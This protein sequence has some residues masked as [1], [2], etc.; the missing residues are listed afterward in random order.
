M[1]LLAHPARSS[2]S[3][4]GYSETPGTALLGEGWVLAVE[5]VS[6][7]MGVKGEQQNWRSPQQGEMGAW[8]CM[9]G[10]PQP[11]PTSVFLGRL[12]RGAGAK[13]RLLGNQRDKEGREGG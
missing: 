11:P 3:G 8:C 2:P 13:Q 5:D 1:W 6:G 4:C 7:E 9:D 12:V 10:D